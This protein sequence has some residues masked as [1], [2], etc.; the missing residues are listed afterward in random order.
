MVDAIRT[1]L[2]R[3]NEGKEKVGF[4]EGEKSKEP[5]N[6]SEEKK[7]VKSKI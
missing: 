4:I 6:D 1:A 3:K 2:N 7:A 5:V